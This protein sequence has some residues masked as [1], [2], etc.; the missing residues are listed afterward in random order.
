MDATIQQLK[1]MED[2]DL[3]VLIKYMKQNQTI[4]HSGL[5]ALAVLLHPHKATKDKYQYLHGVF[6]SW[7]CHHFSPLS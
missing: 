7:V 6:N 5:S 2:D 3:S 1:A 4:L